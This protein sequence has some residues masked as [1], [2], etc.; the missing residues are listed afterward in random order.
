MDFRRTVMADTVLGGVELKKGDKVI[1]Y[2]PS[3]NRD[4]AIFENAN[5]FDIGRDPNP[6]IGFGQ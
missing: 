6:H 4:E 5:T 3:A 2:Y 1:M